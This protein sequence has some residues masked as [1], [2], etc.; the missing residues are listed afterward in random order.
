MAMAWR[1]SRSRDETSGE[2]GAEEVGNAVIGGVAAAL[3][4]GGGKAGKN[5]GRG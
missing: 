5:R 1:G 3:G 2:A 4:R